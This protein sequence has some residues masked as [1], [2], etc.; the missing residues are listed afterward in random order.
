[1]TDKPH[2]LIIGAGLIGLANARAFTSRGAKVT[3]IERKA[4]IGCG[5][6]FSNSGMIH[7]SQAWPW[8]ED[9][10]N[11]AAQ[12]IA[13]RN[14]AKLAKHAAL[15]L[16]Q[17]MDALSLDDRDRSH[18]C[19]QIFNDNTVRKLYKNRYDNIGISAEKTDKLTR[20]ALYFPDDFSGNA[21]SWSR[22]EAAS[23]INDGVIIHTK[24]KI[25]LTASPQGVKARID[26]SDIKTDH[27]ILCAGDGTNL[28]LAPLG[29][30]LPI[31]PVRGFAL[32]FN[33][34]GIDISA[35][36][37]APIMDAASRTALTRFDDIIR[38][39]G[40]LGEASARPLWQ[41]WCHIIPDI[42]RQLRRPHRVWSGDRPVSQL[43]R[44]IISESPIKNLWVN[45]G[46]GHMGW[47]LSMASGELMT[48][49]ILDGQTAPAFAWPYNKI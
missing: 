32:D 10:L 12:L 46:H 33:V 27:I 45:T 43:G 13:A 24:A 25:S 44:P 17:R 34:K 36:P 9:G 35:L 2:I 37:I 22:A 4:E 21:H 20:P 3:L 39:S 19:Y 16:Q 31:T 30:Y 7:P 1:M 29:L 23:L 26:G 47:T 6:G 15:Q 18:G 49:M 41:K 28:A 38:L 48:K 8:V 11:D 14:V 42:M 5:A 40:T